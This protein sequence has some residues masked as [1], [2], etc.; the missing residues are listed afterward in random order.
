VRLI[1]I[2]HAEQAVDDDLD[3]LGQRRALRVRMQP[4]AT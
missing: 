2:D 4:E 3:A 1:G